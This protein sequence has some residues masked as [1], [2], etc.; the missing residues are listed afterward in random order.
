V[1]AVIP[2]GAAAE[3]RPDWP[4]Y[5][6]NAQTGEVRWMC[7][8]DTTPEEVDAFAAAIAR[9]CRAALPPA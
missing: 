8:W 3:V 4:F 6:W 5:T 1:F 2:P 7:S 9:A